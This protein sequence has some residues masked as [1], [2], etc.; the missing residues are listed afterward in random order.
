[1][2]GTDHKWRKLLDSHNQFVGHLQPILRAKNVSHIDIKIVEMGHG[3]GIIH[4]TNGTILIPPTA[5]Q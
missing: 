5:G 2:S 1:M 3:K 4:K